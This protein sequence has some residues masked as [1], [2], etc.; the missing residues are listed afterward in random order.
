MPNYVDE[1]KSVKEIDKGLKNKWR[2]Q[3]LNEKG[4]DGKKFR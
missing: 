3:W 4:P 1:G 2:W